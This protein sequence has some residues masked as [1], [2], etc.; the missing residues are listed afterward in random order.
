MSYQVQ[1]SAQA[2]EDLSSLD[3]SIRTAI[4][5]RLLQFA[6]SPSEGRS[7]ATLAPYPSGQLVQ[8]SF[9]LEGAQ[10]WAGVVFQYSQDE[11]SLI[12]NRVFAEIV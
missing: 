8:F 11:Q 6:K 3:I 12:V 2:D 7:T 5:Q 9:S 10:Y 4:L 1:L